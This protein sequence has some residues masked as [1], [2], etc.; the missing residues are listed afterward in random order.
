MYNSA[1]EPDCNPVLTDCIF[2][3]NTVTHNGGAM[4]N[5]GRTSPILTRCEFIRNSVSQG[6]GGAIRNNESGSPTLTNCVFIKNSAQ[7]FGGAIRSSNG[8]VTILTNCTF[9]D[10]SADNGRAV[11]CTGD[12]GGEESPCTVRII[13]SILW[14][15]GDEIYTG[16]SSQITVN[17]SDVR[18][19]PN[20]GIWPGRGNINS[21]PRFVDTSSDDYHLKSR[22]G[23]WD[24]IRQSWVRDQLTSPCIDAGDP[25]NSVGFEPSPNGGIINMGAY[26]RTS[27]ASKS[28]TG[29]QQ[30]P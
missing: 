1:D 14:D 7:T 17:Y 16:D 10:N 23:H 9:G 4:Y 27:E 18:N 8:G 26:G 22:A 21:N 6:G 19:N 3:S 20:E 2:Q 30:A 12:D 25:S 13:N 5:Y 29:S 15:G 24:P 11:A 28:Y